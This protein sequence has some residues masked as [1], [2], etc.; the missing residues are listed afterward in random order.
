MCQC[1]EYLYFKIEN[2]IRLGILVYNILRNDFVFDILVLFIK[3]VIIILEA[4]ASVQYLQWRQ[5]K[6]VCKHPYMY[7]YVYYMLL[8]TIYAN[9]DTFSSA[10]WLTYLGLAFR[11]TK[12]SPSMAS[13][14]TWS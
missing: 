4:L 10:D 11:L 8:N 3:P 13:V 7:I 1:C 6:D 14:S 9:I 5:V 12:L 2:A